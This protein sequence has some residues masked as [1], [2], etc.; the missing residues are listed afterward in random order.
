MSIENY[1][2]VHEDP[3]LIMPTTMH[4]SYRREEIDSGGIRRVD[5]HKTVVCKCEIVY[6]ELFKFNLHT[7]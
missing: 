2:Y 3:W 4:K 1:T 5:R 6:F 7:R